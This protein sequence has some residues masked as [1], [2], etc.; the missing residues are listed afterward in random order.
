MKWPLIRIL[1][2]HFS[3]DFVK[4]APFAAVLSAILIVA[5]GVGYFTKGMNM[6][7]D[8]AG[9]TL[10]KVQTVGPA[11]LEDLR[12]VM[13]ELGHPTDPQ[14]F[15]ADNIA[16][17]RFKANPG[18]DAIKTADSIKA[19]LLQ[20]FPT[21]K[22]IDTQAVSGKVSGELLVNGFKALGIAMVLMLCYI[23]FRFQLQF[24]F[25][26]IIAILHDVALTLGL[27]IFAKLECTM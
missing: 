27:L 20:R 12:H 3:F 7:P 14:K 22:V 13:R 21:M 18:E 4:L 19:S 6:G 9:G 1:P 16:A 11:P 25:G 23:W 8:F 15:G 24:G 17:M 10:M 5:T 2:H 26:A